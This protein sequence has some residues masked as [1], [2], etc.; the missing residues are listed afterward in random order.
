[1]WRHRLE[2]WL[3]GVWYGGDR[4]GQWLLL[5]LVPL[6]CLLQALHRW[7]GKRRQVRH[8]VP[9]VVVGN[10]TVGGTGKTPL[11]VW[12]VQQAQGLGLCPGVVA[13]GY[14]QQYGLA[15]EAALVQQRT[16]APVVVDAD[17]NAAIRRLL[18]QHGC[19]LVIAD[20]GLQHYRMGRDLEI[21]VLDGQRGHGNG[22]CLPAGPLREPLARLRQCDFVVVNGTDMQLQGDVAINLADGTRQPLAAWAGQTVHAV[23]GIGNPERFFALLQAAGMQ[24][25]PHPFPDHHPFM[26]ADLGFADGLPIL[27]TE[28]DAVKCRHFATAQHWYVPVE[29][30]LAPAL[31]DALRQRLGEL[32][33]G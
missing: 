11:V 30:V 5:P 23:A 10:L 2:R 32:C 6:Y 21:A 3:L 13:R 14:R 18:Q 4:W 15:D 1:M 9:V 27:L 8:P 26:P 17:R 16:G 22:W 20:D 28:K 12:L 25:V 19:G 24:V 33:H 31:A 7:W 29:A